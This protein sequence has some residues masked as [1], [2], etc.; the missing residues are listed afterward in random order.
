MSSIDEIK[1]AIKTLNDNGCPQVAILHCVS[2]YPATPDQMNLK[3]IP[4]IVGRFGVVAGLSDHTLGITSSIA[5]VA[6]GASI[7]EKHV[8][9]ARK[10]GGPDAEFSLEPDELDKLVKAIRDTEKS[11]GSINYQTKKKEAENKIFR[12]SLFVVGDIEKGEKFTKNNI[13]SIRPG[14]G[15]AP[16]YYNK[17]LGKIAK[18]NISAGTPL[19]W[20]LT[21]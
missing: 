12:K 19:S 18:R 4:D 17:I 10:D 6:L 3:T 2:S 15:L 16:K 13:R 5:A 7:I 21:K 11:L 9:L 14:Y 20:N 8:T 1:L